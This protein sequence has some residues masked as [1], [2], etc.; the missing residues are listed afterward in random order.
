MP[1][2]HTSTHRHYLKVDDGPPRLLEEWEEFDGSMFWIGSSNDTPSKVV[3]FKAVVIDELIPEPP[4]PEPSW[5]RSLIRG[6]WR[7]FVGLLGRTLR[8]GNV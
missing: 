7:G 2:K 3:E 4:R 6:L 8:R 1:V 5:W